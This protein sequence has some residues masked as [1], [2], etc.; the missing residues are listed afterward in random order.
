MTE[1]YEEKSVTSQPISE[2]QPSPADAAPAEQPKAEDKTQGNTEPEQ[3]AQP[4]TEDK[5]QGNTE[6]EQD[7]QPKSEDSEKTSSLQT[8]EQKDKK[9][10]KTDKKKGK[11]KKKKDVKLN[12]AALVSAIIS[13]LL[14]LFWMYVVIPVPD[15]SICPQLTVKIRR[16]LD[17][18]TKY[19]ERPNCI[20]GR[21]YD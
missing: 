9:K 5:A 16:F 17:P 14:L 7:A 2:K 11:K 8:A 4:K 10:E 13:G 1:T 6:P 21:Q 12:K 19:N 18:Y 3:D 20:Y 15:D